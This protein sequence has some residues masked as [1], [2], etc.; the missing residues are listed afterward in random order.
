[1]SFWTW[2]RGD[3]TGITLSVTVHDPSLVPELQK[4][5]ARDLETGATHLHVH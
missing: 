2:V 4:R 1:M 3:S 5:A